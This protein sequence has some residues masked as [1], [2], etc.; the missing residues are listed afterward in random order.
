MEHHIAAALLTDAE[1]YFPQISELVSASD[2]Q[3]SM[4]ATVYTVSEVLLKEKR[5]PDMYTI[6]ARASEMELPLDMQFCQEAINVTPSFVSVTA[7]AEAVHSH[8]ISRAEDNIGMQLL[9]GDLDSSEAIAALQDLM[10][11]KSTTTQSPQ[12]AANSMMD[13]INSTL[14]NHKKPYV[15]TMFESL[16]KMLSGGLVSG[17]LITL[18]ARPGT[19]KTTAGICIAENVAAQNIPVLYVSLEMTSIQIWTCRVAN[20]AG[21]NRS[22]IYTGDYTGSESEIRDKIRRASFA[23]EKLY[24]VPFFIRD[25]PSSLEDI[26]RDAR[27]IPNLGLIVV[28]HMGLVKAPEGGGKSRYEIMTEIAHSLKQ[29]ALSMKIPILSLCQLNRMSLDRKDRRPTMADLRDSGAIEEDSDSV[30]LLFR[31]DSMTNT[32][33]VQK[34]RFIVDKNRHGMTGDVDMKFLGSMSRISD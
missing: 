32:G 11:Q 31:D 19:G 2:F 5:H 24:N 1:T 14:T 18:A 29:M 15:P 3:S 25:A 34:I 9:Q 16:D 27:S 7:Y 12:E 26:E 6:L 13:F 30:I 28:D 4:S 23:T 20:Y 10:R 8:A 22:E 17:G 21:L 33:V